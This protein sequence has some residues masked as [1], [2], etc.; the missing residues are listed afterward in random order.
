MKETIKDFKFRKQKL[1]VR[2]SLKNRDNFSSKKS[3][4]YSITLITKG[5]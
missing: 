3:N 2:D 5:T 4:M 1:R